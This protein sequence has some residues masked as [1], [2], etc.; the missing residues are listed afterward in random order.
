MMRL[1]L[2]VCLFFLVTACRKDRMC[3]CR[4]NNGTY[5]AGSVKASRSQ[6]EKKCQS[7]SAG[8]TECYLK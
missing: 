8:S 1:T 2:L 5:D 4:N 7:L 6:A 3:E